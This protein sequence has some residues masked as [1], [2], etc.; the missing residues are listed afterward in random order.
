MIIFTGS[1]RSGTGLYSKLF[2]TYHEYNVTRLIQ[3]YFPPPNKVLDYDPF[4]DFSIRLQIMKDHLIDVDIATFRDSSNPYVSFLYALYTIDPN[5]RIVLGVRDGR[6][7]AISGITRGYY[8]R[9]KYSGYSMTPYRTDPYF[10]RWPK[11]TPL[12]RMAWWWSYR[13][14]KALD[15]LKK[16]PKENW[17]IVRLE[18]L[19]QDSNES[20][21]LLQKLEDF[22]SLKADR[23]WL[24]KKYNASAHHLYPPKEAW[25]TEMRER[26]DSIAGHLMK[27]FGYYN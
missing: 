27:E 24:R 9:K 20:M 21:R 2:D 8:N 3:K 18:D 10:S 25:N 14:A 17:M 5:I 1:G 19:T 26:F 22:V 6:D 7:F 12:E 13:N 11:M 15:R 4:A 23:E 16:V